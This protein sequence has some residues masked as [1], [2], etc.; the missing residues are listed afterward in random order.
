MDI[1][2]Q[3]D[4][5]PPQG[6]TPRRAAHGL[7][8]VSTGLRL[9]VP[10]APP[11]GA[12]EAGFARLQGWLDIAIDPVTAPR[13][14]GLRKMAG[15]ARG[16]SAAPAPHFAPWQAISPV[17]LQHG[18]SPDLPRADW[19]VSYLFDHGPGSAV[20]AGTL[21]LSL[22]S[23]HP[24]V[25]AAEAEGAAPLPRL[26][27]L[28]A[29]LHA[30]RAEGRTRIA[31]IVA[32]SQRNA[33]ARLLLLADRALTRE[34]IEL[35]VLPVEAALAG[36]NCARPRWDA[37]IVMPEWRSIIVA[38]LAESTGRKGPWPMLWH[39]AQGPVLAASEA[40]CEAGARLAFDAPVLIQ[41][42]ALTLHHAGM[43]TAARRLHEAAARLRDSGV[44][45][46]SRGSP[47]PYV[48]TLA[49]GEFIELVCAP[50]SGGHRAAPHWH[51]LEA[52]LAAGTA[53]SPRRL[54]LVAPDALSPLL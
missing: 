3:R 12:W 4:D 16:L 37:L 17:A 36:L 44:V 1:A 21:D 5:A 39:S 34:G 43:A 10:L 18:G 11:Q 20:R 33:M 23:P 50:N 7:R 53:T 31:I 29:M 52:S 22:L 15:W 35:E 30:A 47:A 26:A 6:V 27:V 8:L 14:P 46:A 41:T 24:A 42:L 40:L 2:N 19:A 38:L 25:C 48:K 32:A 54:E 49:D 13:T 28:E 9:A 45:T 51:A